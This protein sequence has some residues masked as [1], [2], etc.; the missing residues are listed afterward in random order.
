MYPSQ[1][2]KHTRYADFDNSLKCSNT[3]QL[4]RPLVNLA[5]GIFGPAGTSRR[6]LIL[7]FHQAAGF[8]WR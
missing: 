8:D 7:H 4:A 3:S 1:V 6:L 2:C 5:A